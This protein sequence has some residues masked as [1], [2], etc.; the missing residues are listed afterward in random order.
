MEYAAFVSLTLRFL[1][2]FHEI[3]DSLWNG[4]AKETNFYSARIG[5]ADL[6]VEPYLKIQFKYLSMSINISVEIFFCR[7][8]VSREKALLLSSDA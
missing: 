8:R 6:D 7:I 4:F 3:L 5:I 1:G 2:E